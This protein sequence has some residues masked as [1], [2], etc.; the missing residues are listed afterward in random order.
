[1]TALTPQAKANGAS[2]GA[3]EKT[4]AERALARFHEEDRLREG[5]DL[6]ILRGLWP[7]LRP[8]T[9]YLVASI[10]LLVVA[11]A[12]AIIRPMVTRHAFDTFDQVNGRAI[13]FRDGF[14]LI[15]IM[16]VER[17][18]DFPQFILMQLAGARAMGDMR[19]HVFRFL[20]TRRLGFFDRTPVGRLV[21]RVTND[22]DA[23]NEMFA[24]GALNAVG[25][26]VKL[27]GIVGAMLVL[28]WRLSLIAFA[29]VPP[30][31]ILVNWTRR[32]IRD[33]FREIRSKTARMNAYLNEQ[34]SGMAVVQAYAREEQSAAEFD[35]INEAYRQANNRSI[36]FD[37]TLD[38]AIEMVASLCVAAMLWYFGGTALRARVSFGTLFAFVQY[39]DMFFVPIRDLSARFTL[40]QSAMAGAERIFQLLDNNEEDAPAAEERTKV[41]SP[42]DGGGAAFELDHVLFEYKPDV[43]I[44]RDVSIHATK[45]EKIALVGATGAGKTTV[46]SLLLRLYDVKEGSVRVSGRDVR[47]IP[48]DELRR[49]FAVVPQEVF[50]FPG[51]VASNIAAGDADVDRTRVVRALERIGALDLFERREGGL[52]AK[53]EERGS[54]FSA[55]ERQLIAFAR[56]LYRDPPILVLDEATANVDSDTESRLQKAVWAA[57]QGRTALI[58]AHRLSTIRAVDRIVVFHKGRVVEQGSHDAL[59]AA[60]GAYAKLYQLQ[61]A[62]TEG[63]AAA[64]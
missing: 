10:V 48:R 64:E 36:V 25:D 37:A 24:S 29:A 51:T 39:I 40:L 63:A 1:M 38:A 12:L 17:A 52:D 32:R 59:L 8:Y 14:V 5:Y 7:F 46:A 55:G 9:S 58:I 6:R 56:A 54:N 57:M 34:I 49:Q 41:A 23:I 16:V 18:I 50:L 47:T 3:K 33:A 31:A 44:L 11:S 43:P 61:F 62:R 30:V 35:D 26:L 21:T 13:F 19:E 45:G 4:R 28:D 22:V 15:A 27:V 2:P 60:G 20:H 42:Q 53:V